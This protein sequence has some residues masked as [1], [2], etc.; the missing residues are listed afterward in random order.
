MKDD[1]ITA[2]LLEQEA[3]GV[4][5]GVADLGAVVGALREARILREP[6]AA[7][8]VPVDVRVLSDEL[9]QWLGDLRRTDDDHVDPL[10]GEVADRRGG[11][12]SLDVVDDDRLGE[13]VLCGQLPGRVDHRLVVRAVVGRSG[14]GDAEPD[15]AVS[16]AVELDAV[17][18]GRLGLIRGR[19]VRGCLGLRGCL[20]R[21][22][23]LLGTRCLRPVDAA[24]SSSSSPHAA[25]QQGRRGDHRDPP[26]RLL[27]HWFPLPG[28]TDGQTNLHTVPTDV[29]T[30]HGT[31]PATVAARRPIRVA[32]PSTCSTENSTLLP[33][34]SV[35][36]QM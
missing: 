6:G 31:S 2:A 10:L 1:R 27:L 22:S 34:G 5:G 33:S 25:T 32:Q 14:G 13:A 29:P 21:G 20:G 4:A 23:R 28:R 16:V 12:R 30:L 36:T 24:P 18:G 26:G 9:R 35:T 15:L 8:A 11:V 17:G 19:G 3:G 7:V